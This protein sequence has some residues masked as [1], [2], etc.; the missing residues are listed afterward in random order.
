MLVQLHLFIHLLGDMED[1]KRF[2]GYHETNWKKGDPQK[3]STKYANFC[4]SIGFDCCKV[5]IP[6]LVTA[7]G[8]LKMKNH[9]SLHYHNENDLWWK[10]P[11]FLKRFQK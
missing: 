1:I 6:K 10:V 3:R 9:K 8:V 2:H 7:T 4:A 5:C 11:T